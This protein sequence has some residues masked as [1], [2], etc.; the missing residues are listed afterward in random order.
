[1]FVLQG[2]WAQI[3]NAFDIEKVQSKS[4]ICIFEYVDENFDFHAWVT[5]CHEI[6]FRIFKS[7]SF[8]SE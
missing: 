8:F 1:M 7:W 6:I 2:V 5:A 3:E 4:D